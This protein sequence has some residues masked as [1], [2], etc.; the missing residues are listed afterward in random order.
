MSPLT[1]FFAAVSHKYSYVVFSFCFSSKHILFSLLISSWTLGLF[2]TSQMF[3]DFPEIFLFL[4]PVL[5]PLWSEDKLCI[6]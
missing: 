3:E 5:N 2:R 6:L 4:I 1:L